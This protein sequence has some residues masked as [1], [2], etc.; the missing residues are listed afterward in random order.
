MEVWKGV[1]G[2]EG[3]YEASTLGRVRSV[4]RVIEVNGIKRNLKGKELRFFIHPKGYFIVRLSKNKI[5]KSFRVHQL[6]A[7][8]FL[9]H[10]PCGMDIVVDHINDIKIDN[11]LINLQ[12]ITNREN[13][14]KS[15][16]GLTSKYT[17]VTRVSTSRW[18]AVIKF[19]SK[20]KHLGTY[21]SELAAAKAYKDALKQSIT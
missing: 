3:F 10:K 17:G 5:G 21:S 2:Y 20:T 7:I 6:I 16:R 15:V 19:N 1:K 4:D 12:L 11:R 9:N 13:I 18:K 8:T 14:S